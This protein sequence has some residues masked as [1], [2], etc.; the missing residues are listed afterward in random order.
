MTDYPDAG[1]GRGKRFPIPL[2]CKWGIKRLAH[3]LRQL[4]T[5]RWLKLVQLNGLTGLVLA[6][7]RL[8]AQTYG[9]DSSLE[10]PSAGCTFDRRSFFVHITEEHFEFRVW[11][12]ETDIGEGHSLIED[13]AF[14]LEAGGEE[15]TVDPL[16]YDQWTEAFSRAVACLLHSYHLNPSQM[17]PQITLSAA[18]EGIDWRTHTEGFPDEADDTNE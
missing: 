16:Q 1:H 11:H 18:N 14:A 4:L 15:P 10:I 9:V 6:M 8:P 3:D 5:S 17:P 13:F 12:L 7:R 2:Q